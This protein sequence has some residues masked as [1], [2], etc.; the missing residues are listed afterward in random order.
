MRHMHVEEH[1][2]ITRHVKPTMSLKIIYVVHALLINE[3][4]SQPAIV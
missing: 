3:K 4:R 1:V 2:A